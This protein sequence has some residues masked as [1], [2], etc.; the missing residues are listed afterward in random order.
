[1]SANQSAAIPHKIATHPT[2]STS[3]EKAPH[4]GRHDKKTLCRCQPNTA[5]NMHACTHAACTL[6]C[7]CSPREAR[8]MHFDESGA[9]QTEETF[10]QFWL[11]CPHL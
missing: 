2:H 11:S 8:N 9:F 1:M 6:G 7:T 5:L 3:Q 4:Q 10:E